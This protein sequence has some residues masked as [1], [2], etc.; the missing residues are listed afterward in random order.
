MLT[1]TLFLALMTLGLL[2]LGG[3]PVDDDDSGDDDATGD[4]DSGDDDTGDDDTGD[5]DA[6]GDDDSADD[7]ATGDDDTTTAEGFADVQASVFDQHCAASN[8]H[9]MAASA[10]LDLR[11]G[12]AYDELVGAASFELPSMDRVAPS[13]L[14][15]SYLFHKLDGTQQDVGGT[16][17]QMPIN[18]SLTADELG[19][20]NQWIIDGAL[21]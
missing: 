14:A 21:P 11:E 1:R 10:N 9:G 5:D 8:C 6:T 20:V 12:A 16:G 3:C 7:D 17:Q 19:L 4:D 2:A 15:N 18:G 13:Q